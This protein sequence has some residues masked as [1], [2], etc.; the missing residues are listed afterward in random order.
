MQKNLFC[1][2]F[3]SFLFVF[4]I[5]ENSHAQCCGGGNGSPMAGGS[6]QGVLQENQF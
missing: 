4:V 1:K 2:L 3:I 5:N 6:S